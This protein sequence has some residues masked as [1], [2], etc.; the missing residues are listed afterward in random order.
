MGGGHRS[1][2]PDAVSDGWRNA[3]I[4]L[5]HRTIRT[6]LAHYMTGRVALCGYVPNDR[7]RMLPE[8]REVHGAMRC[9]RCQE[10]LRR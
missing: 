8:D 6:A 1:R 3:Q 2:Q 10:K 7:T 9:E 4:R 5:E